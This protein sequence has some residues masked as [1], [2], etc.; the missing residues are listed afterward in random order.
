MRNI[1]TYVEITDCVFSIEFLSDYAESTVSLEYWAIISNQLITSEQSTE[2]SYR[3]ILWKLHTAVLVVL[4]WKSSQ[5]F[6]YFFFVSYFIAWC[7]FLRI[8]TKKVN[9]LSFMHKLF[10][11]ALIPLTV[12]TK[13][14]EVEYN[15]PKN[16]LYFR[17]YLIEWLEF[18][19]S[20]VILP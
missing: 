5:I 6:L 10:L 13:Y 14:G 17:L 1:V 11:T 15:K 2:K 7:Y 20:Y 16:K 4:Y 19:I 18:E 3:C 8:F 9:V 12:D